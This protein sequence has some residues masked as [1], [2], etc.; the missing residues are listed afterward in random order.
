MAIKN[1]IFSMPILNIN[2]NK[3]YFKKIKKYKIT[4]DILKR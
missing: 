3:K 2:K 1:I 4:V